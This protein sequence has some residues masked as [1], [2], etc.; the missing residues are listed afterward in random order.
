MKYSDWVDAHDRIDKEREILRKL[1]CEELAAV[2]IAQQIASAEFK[3]EW[4]KKDLKRLRKA[5]KKLKTPDPKLVGI[6][7]TL[8]E[9]TRYKFRGK[10]DL[11]AKLY[12]YS[13]PDNSG[14]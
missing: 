13:K 1:T 14:W 2:D 3:I 9:E 4:A 6:S 11:E 7:S 5:A 10:R 12:G 8:I